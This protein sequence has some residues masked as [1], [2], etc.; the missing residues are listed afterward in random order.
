MPVT[1]R[2]VQEALQWVAP[3]PES[4]TWQYVN[5]AYTW[6]GS[7]MAYQ[8]ACALSLV[9]AVFPA[10]GRLSGLGGSDVIGN[11]WFLLVGDQNSSMK[12][13]AIGAAQDLLTAV[14][15]RA[16]R[17]TRGSYEAAF[18]SFGGKEPTPVQL[19]ISKDGGDFFSR[20]KGSAYQANWKPWLT[21]AFDGKADSRDTKRGGQVYV[22]C[23]RLS[24]LMGINPEFLGQHAEEGD[25]NNG[26]LMRFGFL[27]CD[28]ER[29]VRKY[30]EDEYATRY[31]YLKQRLL[32]MKLCP[33]AAPCIGLEPDA[34]ALFFQ[35]EQDYL[36]RRVPGI[37][38]KVHHRGVLLAKK[39]AMLM[40]WD[41]GPGREGQPWKIP[42][43]CLVPALYFA[44]WHYKS[45]K[46]LSS[47]IITTPAMRARRR[48]LQV[49]MA[50]PEGMW[51]AIGE[52]CTEAQMLL[53]DT[54]K[55]L[56]SLIVERQIEEAKV[57]REL[58]YR[59][60]PEPGVFPEFIPGG[61]AA[62]LPVFE[63]PKG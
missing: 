47:L 1:E 59:I 42:M 49:L 9:A 24:L 53:H 63:V 15:P 16:A 33:S 41:F 55:V 57:G 37:A 19:L 5:W 4:F 7:P 28:A 32:Q 14:D 8:F 51:T 35:W 12:T 62:S 61:L 21:E 29:N 23:F 10:Q 27:F 25:W 20:T 11:I 50:R 22:P 60:H 39:A 54:K 56:A 58:F 34:E 44:E 36:A 30:D 26:F 45:L 46:E 31:E 13:T 17:S 40:G 43:H 3:Y 52:I 48:V 18:D 6:T 38:P 2:E